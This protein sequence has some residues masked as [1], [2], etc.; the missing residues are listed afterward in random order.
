MRFR[1]LGPM[2][3]H[4]S[5]GPVSVAAQR[6]RVILMMILVEAN[7]VV[8]VDRLIEAVWDESP[9]A[10][11][12]G[13]VQICVSMLRKTF[14]DAGL[15][16][17]ITTSPSG[18]MCRIPDGELDLHAFE[19][20]TRTA[21]KA[22]TEGQYAE[23]EERFGQALGLW[24]GT[25]FSTGNSRVL[26]G[27]EVR[28]LEQRVSAIEEWA[29][30]RLRLGLHHELVNDL[31][32]LVAQFPL[33]ERLRARLMLALYRSG[34]QAEALEVYRTGRRVLVDDLGIEPGEELRR[35]E[36]SILA[37][38]PEL[39]VL[40]PA[41]LV[42]PVPAVPAAPV[43]P[44]L[45][46]TDIPDFTGLD[47]LVEQMRRHLLPG[48]EAGAVVG[49]STVAVSGKAGVGKTTLATHVGHELAGEFPDG[50]LFVKLNGLAAQ[51]VT[52]SQALERFL[53]ALGVPGKSVPEGLDERAEMYRQCVADRRILVVLD[54]AADEEQ[55]RLLL[56][57]SPTCAVIVTSRFR[58]TGLPGVTQ[59][60]VGVLENEH[61]MKMLVKIVGSARIYA[62]L[63]E[64]LDLISLCGGLPIALRIAAA[65]LAARPHW[66]VAQFVE[67]LANESQR[68]DEL[69]HRGFGVRANL[70]L[71]Y[72]ALTEPAKRLFRRLGMLETPDFSGCLA[73]PLLD[74]G[75]G[76]AEEVLDEL[77][78]AQ[79]VDV[80]RAGQGGQLRYRLHDLIRA[81]SR[82]RLVQ[83]ESQD[84]RAAAMAR[85][86]G[87]WLFLTEEAHRREYGG[88][89]TLVHGDAPRWPLPDRVLDRELAD[90]IEWYES[91][92]FGITAAVRQAAGSG[93][94]E[95]CWDLALTAVTL[96]EARSYFD[97][98]R[99]T[100]EIALAE[101]RRA[102]NRR[103]EAAML[104]SLG[105]LRLFEQR[106][107][108]AAQR[109]GP[110]ERIFREIGHRHGQ[111]LALRNLAFLDRIQGRFDAAEARC[112]QALAGLREAGDRV[113][114]AHALSGLAQI[115]IERG[116]WDAAGELLSTALG[117]VEASGARRAHAQ[118]L[119]RLGE[120]QLARE[121]FA[122]AEATFVQAVAA[123]RGYG[124]QVG[125]VFALHGLGIATARQ[126]H[127]A[128]E[129][130]LLK[131]LAQA[132]YI[133]DRMMIG[134]IR[135]DLGG[136]YLASGRPEQALEVL[137]QA[138]QLFS[139]LALPVW[140]SR[141]LRAVG[142]VY[143][144]TGQP[145]AA[146]MAWQEALA[147]AETLPA[148]A[149]GHLSD[150]LRAL[151]DA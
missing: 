130:H 18:Y 31:S 32:G 33:R 140:R 151:L 131:A 75:V 133:A 97:D 87:A 71:T 27:V 92:R 120:V 20:L 10:T 36:R 104:Y 40:G 66:T 54:D 62:E 109:L 69:V 85:L 8:P 91:E 147:L 14:A 50:Q 124:D 49:V 141:T 96:F 21:R 17:F 61:A 128:A 4:G 107:E 77:I 2:E 105:T 74:T 56:P 121:D 102:G 122:E 15:P 126:G 25:E 19:E 12:K 70:A 129:E 48:P 132:T 146:R 144:R 64:S 6:Q 38:D 93:L 11:A 82:E 135:L 30:V 123:V 136:V 108:E 5:N 60:E 65:R 13:Q 113:G 149:S 80:D 143:A 22:F 83:D 16:D 100:H 90:P 46:P 86:L 103:G 55:V 72:E 125:E 73:A 23:A 47:E 116:T 26:Q 106:F 148:P 95:L 29:D 43:T 41:V 34:R 57:G 139:E 138:G 42:A 39:D 28:L 89:H 81:Y 98:W 145:E 1:V 53:R 111:S 88:D 114:E 78:D 119:C 127:P 24:R 150:H 44:R 118:I 117:L 63:G 7:R 76:A 58:L 51:P 84:S 68:L 142:N 99:T 59:V 137:T 45:L 9:P 52:A 67:R 94:H 37:G 3:I 134:R 112:E 35:L 110:A 79:F 115:H 101:A